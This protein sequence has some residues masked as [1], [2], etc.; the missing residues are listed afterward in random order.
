MLN[1]FVL[2]Y[3]GSKFTP[4]TY[5]TGEFIERFKVVKNSFDASQAISPLTALAFQAQIAAFEL[6]RLFVRGLSKSQLSRFAA[7]C[8]K[9]LEFPFSRKIRSQV[10]RAVLKS[11]AVRHGHGLLW[12]EA[13]KSNKPSLLLEDDAK[14][15]GEMNKL[16]GALLELASGSPQQFGAELSR[17]FSFYEL[18]I[19]E[20]QVAPIAK[21]EGLGNVVCVSPGASNTTCA[22]FYSQETIAAMIAL[23]KKRVF[24]LLPIDYFIDFFY[25]I[26]QNRVKNYHVTPGP[27]LQG[28][29]FRQ[30]P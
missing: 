8:L 10:S 26:N 28:S 5:P 2:T 21:V 19:S 23:S 4:E 14:L 9:L 3:V 13:I 6:F 27:F 25:L 1:I 12:D 24:D 11:K 15:D 7:A 20:G 30:A 18:G 29:E 16:L 22:S 17:S